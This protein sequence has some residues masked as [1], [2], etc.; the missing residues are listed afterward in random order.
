MAK[1]TVE[2]TP[3]TYVIRAPMIVTFL[4]YADSID[5]AIEEGASR[6]ATDLG[7][8]NYIAMA[9]DNPTA[10]ATGQSLRTT[11]ETPA[12]AERG[13]AEFRGAEEW[14][15]MGRFD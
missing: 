14:T 3:S 5:A 8:K 7:E 4:V 13:R 6:L 10:I 15:W 2:T 1:Q 9:L 12:P 11:A